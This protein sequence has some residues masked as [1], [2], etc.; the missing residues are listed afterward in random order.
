MRD[1]V[2]WSIKR[3]TD[4]PPNAKSRK[5]QQKMHGLVQLIRAPHRML[6]TKFQCHNCPNKCSMHALYHPCTSLY[7]PPPLAQAPARSGK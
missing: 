7:P 1:M 4:L 6:L 3:A 2:P 5:M